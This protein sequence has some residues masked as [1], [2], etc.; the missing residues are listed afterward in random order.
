MVGKWLRTHSELNIWI[1]KRK[2]KTQTKR[3]LLLVVFFFFLLNLLNSLFFF[4]FFFPIGLVCGI[5]FSFLYHNEG[6]K[7]RERAREERPADRW[8]VHPAG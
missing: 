8:D 2:R 5:L 6:K 1:E 4:F 7:G 3:H